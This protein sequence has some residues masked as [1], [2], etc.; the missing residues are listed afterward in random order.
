[1]EITYR[2]A[3]KEDCPALAEFVSIASGGVI[4]FIFHDLIPGVTPIEMEVKNLESA[5]NPR[6]YKNSTVAE[7]DNTIVGMAL[8][9]PSHFHKITEE[10]S[11]FFPAERM[12]HLKP[13]FSA[14]VENSLLLD[15]LRVDENYRGNGIGTELISL[16]KQKAIDAGISLLSLIV[17]ADNTNAQRLYQHCGFE[18]VENVELKPNEFIPHQG[19]CF[20]MRCEIEP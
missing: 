13:F 4:D 11:R 7:C 1:M 12:S 17:F 2:K 8:S 9:I 6:S 19:G 3:Q 14:R 5:D 18:I 10:M 16:T 15:A 20:L